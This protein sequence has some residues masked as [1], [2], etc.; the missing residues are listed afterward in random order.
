MN[1]KFD[2]TEMS[3]MLSTA[4]NHAL[5]EA[6]K[7]YEIRDAVKKEIATSLTNGDIGK[8]VRDAVDMIDTGHLTLSLAA[9]LQRVIVSGASMVLEDSLVE[10]VCRLR[11]IGDYGDDV[12]KRAEVREKLFRKV[13]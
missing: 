11:N 2:E 6:L 13:S 10:L 9:E 1:I 8:A 3:E 12:R 4:A 7:S 5:G